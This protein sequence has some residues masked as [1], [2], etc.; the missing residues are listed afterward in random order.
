VPV[1]LGEFRY[2]SQPSEPP[3]MSQAQ[4]AHV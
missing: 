2:A 1:M 3:V 4:A